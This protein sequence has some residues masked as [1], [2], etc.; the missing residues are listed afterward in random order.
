M[1]TMVVAAALAVPA[2]LVA[3]KRSA[4]KAPPAAATET[5][6]EEELRRKD[7]K[8]QID[9]ERAT[10]C[11]REVFGQTA[12]I[13]KM[14]ELDSYDDRNFYVE[15]ANGKQFTLKIHNGVEREAILDAQN[16]MMLHLAGKGVMCP[17]PVASPAGKLIEYVCLPLK[18]GGT[19]MHGARLLTWVPGKVLHECQLSD[20]M[21]MDAGAYLGKLSASLADF[22]HPATERA[23]AWDLKNTAG[24]GEHLHHLSAQ[25]AALVRTVLAEFEA[26]ITP[27]FESG[28][29]RTSVLMGDYN[30]ANIIVDA[31]GSKV[32]GCIDF[33]DVVTSFSVCELGIALAYIMVNAATSFPDE[34]LT[35]LN[36]AA[37]LYKG[38]CTQH[39]LLAEEKAVLVQL[40]ACRLAMSCT[41]GA[42]SLSK[43]PS[44]EYLKLHA[45]PAWRALSAV[46]QAPREQLEAA[47]GLR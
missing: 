29:L 25:Q 38:Y 2:M 47:W 36:Y 24:I 17:Q 3:Y 7:E 19:R 5:A 14:R 9:V 21:I 35:I 42:F 6:A 39:T 31:A 44:N 22:R 16:K 4:K 27:V 28:K 8:P 10:A 13:S 15:L 11:L 45:Q 34:P 46:V 12:A 26:H 23:H 1:K 37:M 40:A 30:D 41:F 33:G 32:V 18:R 20:E 43:D